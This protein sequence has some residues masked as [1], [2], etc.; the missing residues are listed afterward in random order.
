MKKLLL[1]ALTSFIL[2]L[3]AGCTQAGIDCGIDKD[4]KAYIK[5]DLEVSLDEIPATYQQEVR[6]GFN[7]MKKHLVEQ[8]YKMTDSWS[9]TAEKIQMHMVKKESTNSYPEAF[10]ALKKMLTDESL[11]PFT[12]VSM[13]CRDGISQQAFAAECSLNVGDI[14]GTANTKAFPQELRASL[15]KWIQASGG[16]VSLTLPATSVEQST[17]QSRWDG[18]FVSAVSELSMEGETRLS[19]VTRATLRDGEIMSRQEAAEASEKL[20]KAAQNRK[21]VFWAAVGVFL[22]CILLLILRYILKK[23]KRARFYR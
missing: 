14:L 23:K 22:L 18:N 15:K 17:G 6:S 21:L 7:A 1:L 11:T 9:D 10:E 8:G 12:E 20:L 2:L 19:L 16:T 4:Y 13:D 5:I 3:C